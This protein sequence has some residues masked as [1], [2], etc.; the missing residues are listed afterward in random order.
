MDLNTI[1]CM[2]CLEFLKTIPDN[3]VDL[4]VTDPPY[5]VSQKQN[6]KI[7]GRT[8]I[9]NFGEWDFGFNPEPVLAELRR[10]LKPNGQIYVFCGTQ[11]IPIYMREFIDKWFFRNLLVWY[12]TNP[13]PRL[14]KT[15]Y[16][17]ATEYI[18]YAIKDKGKPSLSTFNFS[19]QSTMHNT[20]ISGALQG[21]ERLKEENGMAIHP[22]QKPLA[23]L[24]KLIEVSSK[25]GSI[26]LDPFMG[27]GSTAVACKELGRI[28]LGCELNPKYVEWANKRIKDVSLVKI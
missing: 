9:K 18:V 22:T 5:N 11:Q 28:Y 20:F 4:V 21:K 6:L 13:P 24:K 23:I 1:K 12:K 10:V 15:N 7:N 25:K 2:D 17:F 8:I 19:S 26:I 27:I 3:S 16:I 14:S